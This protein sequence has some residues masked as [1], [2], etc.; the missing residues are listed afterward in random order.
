[1]QQHTVI[2]E[3][4]CGNLK[5]LAAVRPIV[6]HHHERLDGSGY[7][8]GLHGDEVPLF[9]QIV[10]IVDAFDAMTTS[11]PYRTARSEAHARSELRADARAGRFDGDLVETFVGLVQSG[12][13]AEQ[14]DDE[15]LDQRGAA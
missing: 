5:S 15:R 6:R 11:R 2:G 4:L 7:P 14:G 12:Q 9:A 3:R 8:D 10:A 1:M 13:F